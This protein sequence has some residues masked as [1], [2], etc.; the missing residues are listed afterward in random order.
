MM[1]SLRKD[2]GGYAL[3]YVMVIVFVLCAISMTICTVALRNLQ[4]QEASVKRMEEKYAAQGEIE[5]IKAQL[6]TEILPL[7]LETDGT[8]EAAKKTFVTNMCSLENSRYSTVE[9]KPKQ[10]MF[11][12]S[13][14]STKIVVVLEVEDVV[15][16][17]ET[18][19]ETNASGEKVNVT[20]YTLK[21]VSTSFVSYTIESTGGAA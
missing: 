4:S 7:G 12:A 8:A 18:K 16:A 14:G 11:A 17:S 20:Y 3:L 13:S 6:G 10:L 15:I 1:K 5:K 19:E 9:G 21:E 2:T